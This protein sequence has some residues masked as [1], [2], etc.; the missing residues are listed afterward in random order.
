MGSEISIQNDGC[1]WCGTGAVTKG[2][3]KGNES[4]VCD[5]CE[6]PIVILWD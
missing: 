5:D 4:F 1:P 2:T 3:Y 6:T